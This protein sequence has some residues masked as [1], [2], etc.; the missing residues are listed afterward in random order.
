MN[1]PFSKVGYWRDG[2]GIALPQGRGPDVS[3]RPAALQRRVWRDAPDDFRPVRGIS[4]SEPDG[5]VDDTD[6][7]KSSVNGTIDATHRGN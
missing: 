3:A 5:G 6:S 7:S 4:R 2:G 1:G